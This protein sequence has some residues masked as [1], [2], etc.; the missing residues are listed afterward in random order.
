MKTVEIDVAKFIENDY[1][2]GSMVHR[3]VVFEEKNDYNPIILPN[4]ISRF[5]N[6]SIWIMWQLLNLQYPLL[7]YVKAGYA[8]RTKEI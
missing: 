2:D 3:E 4:L 7:M 8:S 1:N 6:L 5:S